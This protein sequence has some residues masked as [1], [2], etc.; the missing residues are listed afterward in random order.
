MLL[1]NL[2]NFLS[3][4]GNQGLALKSFSIQWKWFFLMFAYVSVTL[5]WY[6]LY[7][8]KTYNYLDIP[9]LLDEY[10]ITFWI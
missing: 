7:V 2:Y 4:A 1:F 3:S 10:I 5:H 8:V 9:F 6:F